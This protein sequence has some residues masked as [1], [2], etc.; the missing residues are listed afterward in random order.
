MLRT[1]SVGIGRLRRSR[2]CSLRGRH[3]IAK[4][5]FAEGPC[6]NTSSA[7]AGNACRPPDASW[8]TAP[9]DRKER[10]SAAVG[11]KRGVESVPPVRVAS[12]SHRAPCTADR[13]GAV[14]LADLKP[15]PIVVSVGANDDRIVGQCGAHRGP[16]QR[17]D[18]AGRRFV[19]HSFVRNHVAGSFAEPLELLLQQLRAAE[20]SGA[21][22]IV[23]YPGKLE[24]TREWSI[25]PTAIPAKVYEA[26]QITF[27]SMVG[28]EPQVDPNDIEQFI[29]DGYRLFE[30]GNGCIRRPS[31]LNDRGRQLRRPSYDREC[32]SRS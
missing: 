15:A 22:R 30:R 7:H 2:T 17:I 31:P 13:D 25:E 20:E 27:A 23:R 28:V 32:E 8:A 1:R 26:L 10:A 24:D 29:Y 12:R 5:S 16:W 6:A 19:Q 3:R 11:L 9:T 14:L 18:R 4:R 21:F